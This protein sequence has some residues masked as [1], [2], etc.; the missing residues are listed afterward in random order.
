MRVSLARLSILVGNVA[1][2]DL[3]VV[4][5]LGGVRLRLEVL[6]GAGFDLFVEFGS[7]VQ[8]FSTTHGWIVCVSCAR[9]WQPPSTRTTNANTEPSQ[10]CFEHDLNQ[11]PVL[12]A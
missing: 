5:L 11:I 2:L 12:F 10:T 6:V 3:T 1:E 4:R 7:I 9:T 8:G